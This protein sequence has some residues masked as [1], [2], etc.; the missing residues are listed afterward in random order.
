MSSNQSMDK[1]N[2]LHWEKFLIILRKQ[3]LRLSEDFFFKQVNEIMQPD[4]NEWH[5]KSIRYFPQ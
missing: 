4:K 3:Y 2:H 5:Q 1:M